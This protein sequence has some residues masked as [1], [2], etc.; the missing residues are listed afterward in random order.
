MSPR[1]RRS[2]VAHA[3]MA[4]VILRGREARIW[5]TL[6]RFGDRPAIGDHLPGSR[7]LRGRVW[8]ESL[9]AVATGSPQKCGTSQGFSSADDL[10][11]GRRFDMTVT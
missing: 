2:A 9:V 8:G 7:N 10:D 6:N 5:L 1:C 4:V 3:D 11:Q